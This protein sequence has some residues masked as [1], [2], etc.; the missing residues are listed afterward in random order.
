MEA[1]GDAN[2]QD[3][4]GQTALQFASGYGKA[5]AVELLLQAGADTGLAADKGA[6][7]L[8]LGPTIITESLV[9]PANHY[10][11]IL[12]ASLGMVAL[13]W[14]VGFIWNC[15]RSLLSNC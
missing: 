11:W 12:N 4:K 9:V 13:V 15:S 1:G 7:V 8:L 5:A 10:D 6:V 2:A 14:R 3:S